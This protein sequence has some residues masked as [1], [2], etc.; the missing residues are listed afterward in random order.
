MRS[1]KKAPFRG[2]FIGY[3]VVC[4][5]GCAFDIAAYFVLGDALF[6][7]AGTCFFTGI[8]LSLYHEEN[9]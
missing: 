4:A 9:T 7:V 3:R 1:N 8:V 6:L 2:F 5:L